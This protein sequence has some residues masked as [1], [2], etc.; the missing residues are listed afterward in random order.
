[1]TRRTA[2]IP[3]RWRFFLRSGKPHSSS[4]TSSVVG[5]RW[6][7]PQDS[8]RQACCPPCSCIESAPLDHVLSRGGG[9]FRISKPRDLR[10]T[11][12]GCRPSSRHLRSLESCRLRR[13][14]SERKRLRARLRRQSRSEEYESLLRL[15]GSMQRFEALNLSLEEIALA[16]WA[17]P[18]L[19]AF[20][21]LVPNARNSREL[22]FLAYQELRRSFTLVDVYCKWYGESALR[23]ETSY[24]SSD[25]FRASGRPEHEVWCDNA[26]RTSGRARPV[27]A[28]SSLRV[29]SSRHRTDA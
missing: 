3:V 12:L 18:L 29:G 7:G 21:S 8:N 27:G 13:Y 9:H 26:T 22:A 10:E 6:I 11:P 15:L 23:L 24:Q 5:T 20:S 25:I 1:M 14:K 19:Q 28:R 17:S 2:I 4:L 16:Y